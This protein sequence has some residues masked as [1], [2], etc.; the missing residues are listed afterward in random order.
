MLGITPKVD[1]LV[2]DSSPPT[3]LVGPVDVA[4]SLSVQVLGF[5]FQ[6]D[7]L[8]PTAISSFLHAFRSAILPTG[9][10]FLT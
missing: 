2:D 6:T 10:I 7:A 8:Q 3:R 4:M 1:L 9:P 5:A